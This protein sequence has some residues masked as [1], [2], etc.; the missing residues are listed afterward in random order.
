MQGSFFSVSGEFYEKFIVTQDY[1]VS[2]HNSY[3]LLENCKFHLLLIVSS[4]DRIYNVWVKSF[5]RKKRKSY[6]LF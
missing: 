5:E 2:T 3:C 6:S 4:F 1:C